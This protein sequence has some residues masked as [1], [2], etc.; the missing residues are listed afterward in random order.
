MEC[1]LTGIRISC[2]AIQNGSYMVELYG[3]SDGGE[4]QIIAP[5]RPNFAQRSSSWAP[6][7]GS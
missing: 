6:A 5:L 3:C 1:R 4:H 2:A 7:F